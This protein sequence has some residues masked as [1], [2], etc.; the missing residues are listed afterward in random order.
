VFDE[1]ENIRTAEASQKCVCGKAVPPI[2]Y[3]VRCIGPEKLRPS[4]PSAT[5]GIKTNMKKTIPVSATLDLGDC[6][7]FVFS[8]A[9][10]AFAKH[11]EPAGPA[12]KPGPAR[13][14]P[15]K[16]METVWSVEPPCHSK[17]PIQAAKD[18]FPAKI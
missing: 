6:C 8:N 10:F 7:I 18:F 11:K 15:M 12:G 5:D 16:N 4:S 3:G 17:K 13:N 2:C 1:A 14:A 9:P